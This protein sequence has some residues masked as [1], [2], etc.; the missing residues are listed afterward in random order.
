[1]NT[2]ESA[3]DLAAPGFRDKFGDVVDLRGGSEFQILRTVDLVNR[4]NQRGM[5]FGWTVNPYRGCEVGCV[6]CYARSTH[7]YLGQRDPRAFDRVIYVKDAD[8]RRLRRRLRAAGASGLEVAIGTATDPYQPGEARFGVTRAVLRALREVGGVRVGITTKSARITRD[9]ELLRSVAD[10][11]DLVVNVS[12][13]SLDAELLRRLEPRAPRPD[14]RLEAV[15]TLTR[16]GIRTR[17]FIMPVLPFITDG[18]AGLRAL[19]SAARSAG[20]GEVVSNTLFLRGAA[21]SFFLGWIARELP[22]LRGRYADLYGTSDYAPPAYRQSIEQLVDR[23]AREQGLP[24][25]TREERIRQEAPAR[26]RQLSLVW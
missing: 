6:Y 14:L 25:R 11:C 13:I 8:P 7:E 21:R 12:L 20:A 17:I 3:R 23:I 9:I 24:G 5:P 22:W 10:S 26:P 15:S 2:F 16:A 18:E 19:V 4:L 1:M